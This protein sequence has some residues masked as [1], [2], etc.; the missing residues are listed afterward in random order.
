MSMAKTQNGLRM[1]VVMSQD[2]RDEDGM[3]VPESFYGLE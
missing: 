1:N 2:E 3:S